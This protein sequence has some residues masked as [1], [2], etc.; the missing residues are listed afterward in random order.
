L[1]AVGEYHAILNYCAIDTATIARAFE[2][3]AG[4]AEDLK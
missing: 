1:H 2:L 3:M 4:F